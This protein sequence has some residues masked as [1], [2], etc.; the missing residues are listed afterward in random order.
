LGELGIE[1]VFPFDESPR[2]EG[3]DGRGENEED[4]GMEEG[5][6]R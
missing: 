3:V 5:L 1:V 2:G 6:G 4:E